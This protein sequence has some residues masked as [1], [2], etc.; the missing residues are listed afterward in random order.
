MGNRLKNKKVIV[1]A[2]AIFPLLSCVIVNFIVYM[3]SDFLASDWTHYD[4]TLPIDRA[5][6]VVPAFSIVYLGCYLFWI[7]NY[8][9]IARQG[10][11]HCIRFAT[12]D[13][14]S[15]LICGLFYLLIPTTNI[16]PV[17]DD[18][19]VWNS[20]LLLVYTI[21]PPTRL[22]PSIHCLVSWFCYIG[23]RKQKNIPK[24]YRVF[25]CMFALLVCLSTQFTK[26]H[27]IVDAIGGILLAEGTYWLALHT[28]LY[29]LPQKGFDWM[30]KK[31]FHRSARTVG[32]R[33]DCDE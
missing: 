33:V 30:Y 11:E 14:M 13:I 4:F 15:R 26:Q 8:I 1:P 18:S 6:P 23:I 20:V 5:V 2:Y 31:C 12:A 3:G 21:D 19:G 29:R 22:F 25:S 27:Y 17:L 16:R 10:E 28:E 7:V 32:K 9:L 24:P